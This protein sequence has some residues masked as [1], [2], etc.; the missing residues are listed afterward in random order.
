M[1]VCNALDSGALFVHYNA[2]QVC[3]AAR[4]V[5]YLW[6]PEF[7]YA[8]VHPDNTRWSQVTLE[9]NILLPCRALKHLI[10]PNPKHQRLRLYLARQQTKAKNPDY[11]GRAA[12]AGF[13]EK[14][15][16]AIQYVLFKELGTTTSIPLPAP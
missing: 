8:T 4:N 15:K 7:S 14:L 12:K 1:T 16:K 9:K 10:P 13:G 3:E 2:L 6:W 5:V 11:V